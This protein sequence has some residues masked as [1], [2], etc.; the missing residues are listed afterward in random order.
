LE[1][2]FSPDGASVA[3]AADENS[4]RFLWLFVDPVTPLDRPPAP[5]AD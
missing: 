2:P 3:V 4:Y 1:A 5:A